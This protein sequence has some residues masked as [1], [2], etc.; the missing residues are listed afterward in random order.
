MTCILLNEALGGAI[1]DSAIPA[2]YSAI[3]IFGTYLHSVSVIVL[4]VTLALILIALN[5]WTFVYVPARKAHQKRKDKMRRIYH[6]SLT[7]SKL[8]NTMKKQNN[9]RKNEIVKS[10][11]NLR[12]KM[13]LSTY[14]NKV[15][16]IIKRSIQHAI[17]LLSFRRTRHMKS[18]AAKKVWCGMNRSLA[19]QGIVDQDSTLELPSQLNSPKNKLLKFTRRLSSISIP[20]G[21]TNMLSSLN[22]N[23]IENNPNPHK[24]DRK[25][26]VSM[27]NFSP[28]SKSG[29]NSNSNELNNNTNNNNNENDNDCDID[30]TQCDPIVNRLAYSEVRKRRKLRPLILFDSNEVL[31]ELRS[32]LAI[33]N[34]NNINNNLNM[35]N[36]STNNYPDFYN[37]NN[38]NNNNKNN[39]NII[40]R[41]SINSINSVNNSNASTPGHLDISETVLFTEL[42]RILQI[43]YPDGVALSETEKAEACES[44]HNWKQSINEHFSVVLINLKPVRV[45]IISFHA[46]EE[47]FTRDILNV[48]RNNLSDRLLDNSLRHSP[49]I[50]RRLNMAAKNAN[51][52]HIITS[53][54]SPNAGQLYMRRLKVVT[55]Q[56]IMIRNSM[57]LEQSLSYD[58]RQYDDEQKSNIE[59]I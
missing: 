37:R 42:K 11:P 51:T 35:N 33:C 53:P 41:N 6:E 31:S 28:L 24:I 23:H 3:Y 29:K 20:D 2:F 10:T 14:C 59:K 7:L 40:D 13:S 16:N 46:F 1:V 50:K 56:D 52:T 39:N 54:S 22:E 5:Y 12:K 44:Y 43:Y 9:I 58:I 36:N 27:L 30:A 25:K 32:R 49:N 17:T 45:R 48:I 34:T 18:V 55:P 8:N 15:L 26:P 47:W 19:F 38:N 21:V 4:V 57:N